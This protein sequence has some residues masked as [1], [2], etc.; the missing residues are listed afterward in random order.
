MNTN[1]LNGHGSKVGSVQLLTQAEL[2]QGD[3]IRGLRAFHGLTLHKTS[4]DSFVCDSGTGSFLGPLPLYWHESPQ[5]IS[6]QNFFVL[7]LV[8][9]S[10]SYQ[11]I[12]DI[13]A[14]LVGQSCQVE[15]ARTLSLSPLALEVYFSFEGGQA[16]LT[17]DWWQDWLGYTDEA[18][19]DIG[20]KPASH[21]GLRCRLACFDMDST[22]IKAE[23]IDE[24]A[25]EAGLME[26]VS[27]ITESA[28]RGELDFHESFRQRLGMLAGLPERAVQTVLQRIE[29][30]DGAEALFQ[31]LKAQGVYTAI[32][33]GGFDVFARHVQQRLGIDEIHANQLDFVDENL[34]G[35]TVEPIMDALRKQETL[36]ALA[37]KLA[38]P[39]AQTLAVGD[40]ANDLL[41]LEA[42]GIGIAFRAKPRVQACARIA[43][44]HGSLSAVPFFLGFSKGM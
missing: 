19:L 36:S 22:L 44:R 32:L 25:A 21:Q 37:K 14:R 28:M 39:M 11:A 16:Q 40:G 43:I 18:S 35:Q 23:V 12:V 34:T 29:L 7:T 38:V 13:L 30:M 42:A 41:M 26:Q 33:S 27:A 2:V 1:N 15:A 3:W 4:Q 6:K 9:H 8:G 5:A 10:L 20:I 24:L 31:F 17:E